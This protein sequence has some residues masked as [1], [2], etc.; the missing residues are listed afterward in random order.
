MSKLMKIEGIGEVMAGK[1]KDAGINSIDALLH[2]GSSAQGRKAIAERASISEKNVLE[3]VNH[4]D[5]IRIKGVGGQYA[6]LL[7][8]AGVD[9]VAEL[10]QRNP[11]ILHKKLQVV[12]QERKLVRRLPASFEVRQ[13]VDQAEKLPRIIS[14]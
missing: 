8:E 9:T 4:A 7:E 3:W 13:W 12:N 6:D 2:Q 11:D 10:A 14:Y 1:L 5:L